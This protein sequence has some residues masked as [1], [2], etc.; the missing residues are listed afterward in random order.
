MS[1]R[2][3][4]RPAHRF[5][6]RHAQAI[7]PFTNAGGIGGDGVFI[8]RDAGGGAFCFDPWVL[9][10]RGALDDPNVIVLGK[11]GQGKSALVKTLLW[12]MLLFGRRAF[13]LDIKREY[14]PLCDALGVRPISL[15]P[16]GGVRLN[17]LTA[18]PEEH[19]QVELLRAIA[20]TAIGES[21]TQAEG[22]ALREALRTVRAACDGEPTLPEIAR[23]L[24][25]PPAEMAARL[26]TTPE[27]L[28]ADVRRAALA[29]QDLCEG[30]LRGMF[31]GPTS[32]GLDLEARLLVLDLHEVRDSPAVGILM[33][34]ATAWMS[35]QLARTAERPGRERLISVADESWKIIQH[36]GLGE[37]FQSN[38]KLAR[39][40]GVMNLVVL[41][42]LADLQTVG[43]AGSRAARIAE[44][45]IADA[46]TRIVYHQDE[47]QVPLTRT[48]LGLSETEARLL[49]RLSAGQAL[50]QV[51]SQSFVVHHYRSRLEMRLTNTDTAMRI[52]PEGARQA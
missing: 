39:Q 16:G 3:A 24:F 33:A 1:V 31:D 44:G 37:W 26:S 5:T 35:A 45:L 23:V 38:F 19:A 52:R 43:D 11:L 2:S 46:S 18:R 17:P 27:S 4:V 51:G 12:R 34:C 47:S 50:W 9:Y 20:T 40:F 49:T 30:P 21:V 25:A 6:T 41:H 36:T 42:K 32:P 28:A 15:V 10:G 14:G 22:A 8:G 13:V 7:Y 29:I 48:L